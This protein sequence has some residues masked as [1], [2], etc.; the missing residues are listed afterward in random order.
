MIF[1]AASISRSC[2]TSDLSCPTSE[3]SGATLTEETDGDATSITLSARVASA[4]KGMFPEEAR[5][6]RTCPGSRCRKSSLR[7][8]LS[9]LGPAASPSNCCNRRRSW[10][11]VR[12]PSSSAVNSWQRRHFSEAVVRLMSWVRKTS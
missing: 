8:V 12:P 1:R 11:G 6:I 10:E 9:G 2:A 5:S 7:N 3:V 4:S